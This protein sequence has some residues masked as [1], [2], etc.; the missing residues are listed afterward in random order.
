MR[1]DR[2]AAVFVTG[3]PVSIRPF[4]FASPVRLLKRMCVLLACRV[5][6]LTCWAHRLVPGW[7]GLS[8]IAMPLTG[9]PHQR[10][11]ASGGAHTASCLQLQVRPPAQCQRRP[12]LR[13]PYEAGAACVAVRR[14]AEVSAHTECAISVTTSMVP[15]ISEAVVG[16]SAKIIHTHTGVSTVSSR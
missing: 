7:R 4:V 13:Q 3:A 10:F 1:C 14:R 9:R 5:P 11:E 2:C 6:V 15:P 12:R 16:T 8:A